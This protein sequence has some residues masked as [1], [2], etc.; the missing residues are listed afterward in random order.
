MTYTVLNFYIL[1]A[2]FGMGSVISWQLVAGKLNDSQ[3]M[4]FLQRVHLVTL[5]VELPNAIMLD[6]VFWGL[7][8][9]MALAAGGD[10]SGL[11][12]FFSFAQHLV[13]VFLII[14]DYR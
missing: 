4:T 7:L 11:T 14:G 5:E 9:P 13:N 8:V 2:Y 12:N 1:T 3:P 6:L 10:T